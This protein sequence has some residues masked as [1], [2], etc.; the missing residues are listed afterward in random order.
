MALFVGRTAHEKNIDFLIHAA[1]RIA[2]FKVPVRILF[3]DADLPRNPNGK[4]MKSQ[5]RTMFA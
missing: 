1:A 2:R 3:V 5:L 4:I